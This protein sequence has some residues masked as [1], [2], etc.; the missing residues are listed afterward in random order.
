MKGYLKIK[1]PYKSFLMCN[2]GC[3]ISTLTGMPDASPSQ[4]ASYPSSLHSTIP[5]FQ[6]VG[7][8]KETFPTPGDFIGDLLVVPKT[9]PTDF[10]DFQAYFGDIT[11]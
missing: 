4:K 5:T 9:S 2:V 3:Q 1:T 8:H 6:G 10:G 7:D 11:S